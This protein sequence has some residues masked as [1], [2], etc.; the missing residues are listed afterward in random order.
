MEQRIVSVLF[1]G[2][3][4]LIAMTCGAE[5]LRL[6]GDPAWAGAFGSWFGGAGSFAAAA[7]AIYIAYWQRENVRSE[8]NEALKKR[9]SLLAFKVN[10]YLIDIISNLSFVDDQE[11]NG[12]MLA[13]RYAKDRRALSSQF[14]GTVKIE[15]L[16]PQTEVPL[17]GPISLILVGFYK[18]MIGYS[19]A[20][21]K[22]NT[23]GGSELGSTI[24]AAIRYA[25]H[26]R[27]QA[28]SISQDALQMM[29]GEL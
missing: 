16:D 14:F 20:V 18:D 10:L 9:R 4:A 21:E 15:Q 23:C 3:M 11:F 5:W 26:I 2:V 6:M 7:T 8:Q 28:L 17:M 13:V 19:F 25:R 22:I 1:Y 27:L 29:Q 12:T 24:D